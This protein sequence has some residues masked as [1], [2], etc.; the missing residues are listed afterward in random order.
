MISGL[1]TRSRRLVVM[2]VEAG[3][4]GKE[5]VWFGGRENQVEL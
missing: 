3:N 4:K 2:F 5:H 1:L